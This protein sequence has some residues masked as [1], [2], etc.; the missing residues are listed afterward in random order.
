MK[1]KTKSKDD[2][3]L[4]LVLLTFAAMSDREREDFLSSMNH[5]ILASPAGRRALAAYWKT[6]LPTAIPAQ[7]EMIESTW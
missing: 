2:K 6:Q 5:F 3:K 1:L 4:A 7:T